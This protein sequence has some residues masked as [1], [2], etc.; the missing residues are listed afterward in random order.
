[1]CGTAHSFAP[2]VSHY[3]VSIDFQEI[4]REHVFLKKSVVQW[5]IIQNPPYLLKNN[6]NPSNIMT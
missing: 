6:N 3:E 4:N 2:L 5:H 1:M